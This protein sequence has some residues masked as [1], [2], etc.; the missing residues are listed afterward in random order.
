[1]LVFFF[2][3]IFSFHIIQIWD[4]IYHIP[5]YPILI[6]ISQFLNII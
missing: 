3:S 6:S 2:L 1:M 5:R 4:Q